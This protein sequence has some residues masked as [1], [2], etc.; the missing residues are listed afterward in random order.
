MCSLDLSCTLAWLPAVI[1][2]FVVSTLPGLLCTVHYLRAK[3]EPCPRWF[4][5]FCASNVSAWW[6]PKTPGIAV[7]FRFS[8]SRCFVQENPT[9]RHVLESDRSVSKKR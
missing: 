5:D 6:E 9:D 7:L 4:A 3:D 2:T 1:C 8:C